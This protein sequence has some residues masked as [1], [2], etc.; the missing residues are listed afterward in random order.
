MEIFQASVCQRTSPVSAT[1]ADHAALSAVH[2]GRDAA[3]VGPDDRRVRHGPPELVGGRPR[4]LAGLELDGEHQ[5]VGAA[6]REDHVLAVDERALPGVPLGDR[7]AVVSHEVDHPPLFPGRGVEAGDVA[8]GTEPDDVVVR[9][10]GHGPAHAVVALDLDR[11]REASRSHAR[12]RTT[13]SASRP[14]PRPGRSPAGRPAR[15]GSRHRRTPR[16]RRSP[17]SAAVPPPATSG[18]GSPD[19]G[20]CR[21]RWPA[22][23]RP[24]A[25]GRPGGAVSGG[26]HAD[27][28]R[29]VGEQGAGRDG[30]PGPVRGARSPTSSRTTARARSRS[31]RRRPGVH[32]EGRTRG[33]SQSSRHRAV[34]VPAHSRDPLV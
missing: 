23:S 22:E 34:R 24:G 27:G 15:R 29:Q 5:G 12:R 18:R 31:R 11:V 33:G 9:H 8:L 4:D 25:H 16:R 19:P 21:R 13:G 26:E 1:D 7:R 6:R 14:R 30:R 3:Q 28:T 32:P 10:R 20:R 2:V 17:T